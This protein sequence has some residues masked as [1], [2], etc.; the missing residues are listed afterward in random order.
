MKKARSSRS[1]F[2]VRLICITPRASAPGLS[3]PDNKSRDESELTSKRVNAN[4]K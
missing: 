1:Q 4:G 3:V 2:N